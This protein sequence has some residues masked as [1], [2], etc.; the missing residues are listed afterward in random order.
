MAN[1]SEVTTSFVLL[2]LVE[3][4][5]FIYLYFLFSLLVYL[6]T[7]FLCTLIVFVIWTE[8][9]LHEPMYMF[10]CNLVTNGAFGSSVFFPKLMIDL[11]SGNKMISLAGCLTQAFCVHNFASVEIFTFTIMAHDRYLAIGQPL[12]YHILMTNEKALKFVAL[13]WFISVILVLTNILLTAML[14]MCGKHINSIICENMSLVTLACG[15]TSVNNIYGAVH[16]MLIIL[17]S[18][19]YIVYTYIMT[20]LICLKISKEACQKAL[21]TLTPHMV[22]YSCFMV[23][24][25][26]ILLRYR[27]NSNSLSVITHVFL[28][29]SGLV[30]SAALNPLIFGIRIENLKIKIIHNLQKFTS[31]FDNIVMLNKH[32]S[33]CLHSMAT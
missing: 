2:G 24:V 26:F 29:V 12:R 33:S 1:M 25:L 13:I 19:L 20:L 30:I 7:M 32:Q 28:A 10:I 5:S 21:R 14:P 18:L 22:S 11:L 8:D 23:T 3:M 15:D 31:K 17:V 6:T 16:T 9:S 27:L 4:E